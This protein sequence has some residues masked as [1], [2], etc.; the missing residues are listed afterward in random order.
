E[1]Q[2][3]KILRGTLDIAGMPGLVDPALQRQALVEADVLDA[4][5]SRQREHR[6][7]DLLVVHAPWHGWVAEG[8]TRV[9]FPRGDLELRGL[10]PHL[11]EIARPLV[12]RDEAV[13]DEPA[14][15]GEL[16]CDVG[17]PRR[18]G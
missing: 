15:G 7:R 16:V 8:Q 12:R 5:L 1:V 14:R 9:A 13:R 10:A 17:R 4:E 3:G 2:I 11:V 6:V 18:A